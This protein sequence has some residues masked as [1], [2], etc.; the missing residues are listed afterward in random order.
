MCRPYA[1]ERKTFRCCVEYFGS[2]TRR[3]AGK[4]ISKIDKIRSV[5]PVLSLAGNIRELQ[6][7]VERSVIL[8]TGDAFCIDEAWLSSQKAPHTKSSAP[9]TTTSGAMKGLIEAALAESTRKSG[10]PNGAPPNSEFRGRRW[11]EIQTLNYKETHHPVKCLRSTPESGTSRILSHP[12]P[13]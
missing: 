3:K 4:Q 1:N 9:L 8:C 7:I 10:R 2:A 5:V 13:F 11:I 12:I 6:N